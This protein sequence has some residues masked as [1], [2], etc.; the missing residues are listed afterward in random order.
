MIVAKFGGSAVTPR[1]LIYLLR[2]VTPAHGAVVVSAVGR[3]Y[4]SDDKATDLLL[5]YYDE[6]EERDWSA[7][8][9]KYRRLAVHNGIPADIDALLADAKSRAC[10]SREYCASLGEELSARLVSAAL[11]ARYV[12]AE[13][14]VRFDDNG[15][16]LEEETYSRIRTLFGGG[17]CVIG[18]FYGGTESGQR[19]TFSRGGGDVT[20][21]IVAAALDASLYE[22]WTDVQGVCVADPVK[23]PGAA[24]VRA[25]S[26]A[27]MRRLSLA[28]AE[29][30]HPDAVEPCRR[31]GIPIRIAD[32]FDPDGADTLISHCP[33]RLRLLSVT[34]RVQE[35]MYTACAL[36]GYP[37]WQV[38]SRMS[39]LV[40]ART[41]R[42]ET[43]SRSFCFDPEL[44][45]R[46]DDGAV[47]TCARKPMLRDLYDCLV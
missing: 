44:E 23:V 18:G 6:R 7:V 19:R 38:M 26:Y 42:F 10:R 9:D 47:H 21:A 8:E 32:F 11:G 40:R 43:L 15:S 25:M 34:E 41:T 37:L 14:A 12:E 2:I 31:L 4:R 29:V 36:H 45:I 35:N 46:F 3:E 24:T 17:L 5:R 30:L 20:G 39:E 1:N 22:N 16:L 28:G 27:E 13:E 33:S